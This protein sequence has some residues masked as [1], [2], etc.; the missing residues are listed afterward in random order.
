V[1]FKITA[2]IELEFEVHPHAY[3]VGMSVEEMLK[4]DLDA[5]ND[6]TIGFFDHPNAN[7]TI[8]GEVVKEEAQ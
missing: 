7:W 1:K 4:V 6:D 8:T 5:A 2:V 3:P